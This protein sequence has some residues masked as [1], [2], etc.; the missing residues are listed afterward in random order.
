MAWI[1]DLPC[2]SQQRSASLRSSRL[3]GENGLFASNA[4]NAGNAISALQR[5]V[6]GLGQA[7]EQQE[8]FDL[9]AEKHTFRVRQ[10]LLE[11]GV[12]FQEP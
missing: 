10:E 2:V 3:C 5:G 6:V 11:V 9:H 4:A 8:G 1:I 7:F 12:F